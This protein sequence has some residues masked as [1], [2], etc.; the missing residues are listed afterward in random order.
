MTWYSSK[1]KLFLLYREIEKVLDEIERRKK[2][3]EVTKTYCEPED[4]F[5][6]FLQNVWVCMYARICH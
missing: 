1:C 5:V 6:S 4:L 3:L 2:D